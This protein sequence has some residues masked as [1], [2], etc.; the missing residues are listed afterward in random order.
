[1]KSITVILRVF[2]FFT[3]LTGLAYPLFITGVAQLF[4]HSKA[5]GSILYDLG[6]PIGSRL[7]GQSF[8]S[9]TIYFTSRPSAI[10]YNPLPSGGSNFGLTNKKQKDLFEKRKENFL[11]FNQ[12]KDNAEIP[13]EMLFASGSGLDPHISPEAALLQVDRISMTRNYSPYQKIRLIRLVHELTESPQF[14][15]LGQTRINVLV[16]NL[17]TDKINE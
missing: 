5:N 9:S 14:L 10:S 7:I 1:M 6:K 3:I 8:D 12:I 2:F 16:L 13:S 17:E 11:S 15:C 4:F